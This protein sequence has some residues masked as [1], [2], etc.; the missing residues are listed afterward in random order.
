MF[1]DI[2]SLLKN[3]NFVSIWASQI[4]SQLTINIMNFVLLVR[5]FTVTGSTIATSLLWVAYAIPAILIGPFAA[6]SV[7]MIDRRKILITTNLLQAA[8]IF[9]YALSHRTS[10]FLLYGVV[11]AYSFLNQFYVPAEAATLPSVLTRKMLPQGNGL[12]LL[13]QQGALI[14]GFGIA[15][16]LNQLLGFDKTLFLCAF[17]VF[18]AFLSVTFLPEL[19]TREKIPRDFEAALV[20]FFARIMEGYKFIKGKPFIYSPLI[21]L[22]G[23]QIGLAVT[24]VNLPAVAQNI[25]NIDLNVAGLFI[26]V[27]AAVGATFGAVAAPKLIKKGWRKKRI[28]EISLAL[29]ALLFFFLTFP[30]SGFSGTLKSFLGILTVFLLGLAFVGVVIPSQTFLQ[31]AT[32]GGLRGRVF[33]N[34]WFLATIATIFPAIFSGTVTELFGIRFL[35][36]ILGLFSAGVLF[37]LRKFGHRIIAGPLQTRAG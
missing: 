17:L 31:E 27:P 26:I 10:F 19:A 22:M 23:V 18:L 3:S 21:L 6:A 32:P 4:F 20:K 7:D 13:T 25:L 28:I 14:L 34:F 8:T 29:L 37:F 5:L 15:G 12:F 16:F 33:G 1:D 35:V 2:K 11:L 9:L 24:V 36:F 30:I